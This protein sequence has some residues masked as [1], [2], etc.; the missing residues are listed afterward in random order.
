M[1][2]VKMVRVKVARAKV[3]SVTEVRVCS[4]L[5]IGFC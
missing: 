1:V 4:N 5:I 2:R 3:E